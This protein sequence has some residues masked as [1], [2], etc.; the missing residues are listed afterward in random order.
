MKN[1]AHSGLQYV[2]S[3]FQSFKLKKN[4]TLFNNTAQV[5]EQTAISPSRDGADSMTPFDTK[6]VTVVTAFFD[7]GKFG[8]DSLSISRT[9]E[10]YL[11]WAKTFKYLLNPLV[12]YTDSPN[13]YNH[14]LR[15]RTQL[16]NRTRLFMFNRTSSWA[17]QRR[18]SIERIFKTKG[19]PKY[20]PNTVLPEY[21]CAM[22]AK[23]DVINRA[24]TENY[25]QTHYFMWLDVGLFRA[26]INN[27][28]YFKLELP[29][30]F[31]D[32]RIAVNQVY[33]ASM[34]LKA[35]VIMKQ[36]LDWICGC[37]FLGK[38]DV[39]LKYAEQYKMAVD[40]FLSQNLMNSDQQVLYAMYAD[41]AWTKIRPN[42]GLQ[43]YHNRQNPWF[44][45]GYLMR[46]TVN[47]TSI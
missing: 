4:A 22:H 29:P 11:K 1:R 34:S 25:F 32:S 16:H 21:S 26:Q 20:Y 28:I 47:L 17:F 45:L 41:S 36:K 7:I 13:F 23:Y 31:N 8:K 14:M 43:L 2:L 9:P 10:T 33:T 38:R 46:K 6:L 24:A 44:Y 30:Y 39:I 5:S 40:Y 37:I 35:S 18:D 27:K 3:V 12:I 42:M 19:Y 15:L